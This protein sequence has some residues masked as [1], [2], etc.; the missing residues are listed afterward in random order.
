MPVIVDVFIIDLNNNRLL[1]II[2]QVHILHIIHLVYDD[3]TSNDQKN[4]DTELGYHH[5]LSE[6]R[7]AFAK[8]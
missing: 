2:S 4:G 6:E 1:L 5:H 8:F 7:A 3:D